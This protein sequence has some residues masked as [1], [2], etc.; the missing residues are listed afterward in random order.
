MNVIDYR[1]ETDTDTEI[2]ETDDGNGNIIKTETAVTCTTLYITVTHK[3]AEE[4]AD[5]YGFDADQREQLAELLADENNSL[6]TAV[7]YGITSTDEEIV[8]VALSQIGS[9]GGEPY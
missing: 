7:L 5:E 6:W 1:T 8:A 3:T 4:M 9:I 2:I